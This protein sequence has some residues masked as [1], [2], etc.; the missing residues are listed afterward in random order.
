VTARWL[1]TEPRYGST[2]VV[3]IDVEEFLARAVLV[4]DVHRSCA[5]DALAR[6]IQAT[7]YTGDFLED[8]PTRL[9]Q[10]LTESPSHPCRAAQG[11]VG[12]LRDA[13]DIDGIVR[14]TL[15]LLVHDPYDEQAHLD[16]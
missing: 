9:A 2:P 1:P 12:R 3:S 11:L 7:G 5:P 14:Y 6:L 8:D 16:W 4:L 10:P 13:S 15:R